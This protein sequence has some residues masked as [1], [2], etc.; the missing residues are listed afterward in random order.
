MSS[1][2][3]PQWFI[4]ALE[5]DPTDNQLNKRSETRHEWVVLA[6]LNSSGSSSSGKSMVKVFNVSKDGLGFVSRQPMREQERI[7]IT[8]DGVAADGTPYESIEAVTV[9]CRQTIQGY[10]IGCTLL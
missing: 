6:Q 3:L 2:V 5:G 8:P 10:K 9:Y 1:Q 7:L 4:E